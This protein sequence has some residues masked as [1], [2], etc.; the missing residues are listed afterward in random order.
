[1]K[2]YVDYRGAN[3]G[4]FLRLTAD[5]DYHAVTYDLSSGGLSA[6][7]VD[8]NLDSEMGHY[9]CRRG[10]YERRVVEVLRKRGHRI[11]L[12]SEVKGPNVKT[13][14]GTYDGHP[15]DIK[16]VESFGKWAIKDKFYDGCRQGVSCLIL[17]FP[18]KDLY[19][20]ERMRDGWD[21]F[22][23]NRYG[24]RNFQRIKKVVCVVEGK[25]FNFNLTPYPVRKSV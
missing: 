12:E 24:C 20:P 21:K 15:M 13:P 18:K 25:A 16:S 8:H 1:M 19:S 10:D 22:R 7:H 6:V 23:A 11:I 4:A 2:N 17:Y 3:Y 14:D 9:G 5:R